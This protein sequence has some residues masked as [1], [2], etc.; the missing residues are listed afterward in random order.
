MSSPCKQ[1]RLENPSEGSHSTEGSDDVRDYSTLPTEMLLEIFGHLEKEKC[2]K[3]LTETCPRFNHILGSRLVLVLDLGKHP[4]L[5]EIPQIY[6]QY[7]EVQVTGRVDLKKLSQLIISSSLDV[8]RLEIK[9]TCAIPKSRKESISTKIRSRAL[10]EIFELLPGI[11]SFV[12]RNIEVVPP[13]HVDRIKT[14]EGP[15]LSQLKTVTV[16]DCNEAIFQCFWKSKNVESIKVESR[17]SGPF[18]NN[19]MTFLMDQNRLESLETDMLAKQ[20]FGLPKLKKLTL[21]RSVRR[22]EPIRC[23]LIND[24]PSLE[25]LSL[26][27]VAETR[28]PGERSFR[29]LEGLRSPNLTTLSLDVLG[30]DLE[31]ASG[32]LIRGRED[33]PKLKVLRTTRGT[34]TVNF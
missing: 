32:V 24:S 5:A 21:K 8:K 23:C 11:E 7:K 4:E 18:C 20:T 26:Q 13:A 15:V 31:I 1:P 9:N 33:L 12:L 34:A 16:V 17:T 6:R 29:F 25:F 22:T 14:T 27:Q 10:M 30:D 28:W 2:V 3:T 19:F